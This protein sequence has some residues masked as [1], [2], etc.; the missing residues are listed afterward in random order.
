MRHKH[1]R[2]HLRRNEP[3]P[4]ER[5]ALHTC[6]L[7]LCFLPLFKIHSSWKRCKHHEL[8]KGQTRPMREIE[9]CFECLLPVRKKS[10]NK[11]TQNMY[12]VVSELL[13]TADQLFSKTVKVLIDRLQPFERNRF[14]SNQR[15]HNFGGTHRLQEQKIFNS[16]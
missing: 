4:R 12:A 1:F 3:I 14:H 8:S 16:L 10:K 2:P 15:T 11:G 9:S 5:E 6:I 13:Q 7:R